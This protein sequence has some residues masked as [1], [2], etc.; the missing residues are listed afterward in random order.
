MML[1]VEQSFSVHHGV[2]KLSR[3]KEGTL[4]TIELNE[5]GNVIE[6]RKAG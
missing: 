1:K 2:S 5:A 3:M 4:I 6:I